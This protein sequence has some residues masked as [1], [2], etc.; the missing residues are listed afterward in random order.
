M[1]RAAPL[2]AVAALLAGCS[3]TAQRSD[4]G[5][6]VLQMWHSQKRQ[7]E[8]TLKLVVE[9]FNAANPRYEVHLS[10]V[11][12]YTA[13]F[14]KARATIQGGTLPDLCIAY[15]SMVAEFMEADV[16]LPLDDSFTHPDHGFTPE[17]QADIFPPFIHCNRYPEFDNKLLSFPFT[18]S[19]LMLYY[20]RD[21]LRSAGIEKPPATWAEFI[22]QCRAIKAKTG[23]PAFA[24]SRDP[25]SFD[26]MIMSLGGTLATL[27]DRRSHLDS[28]EAVRVLD[29]LHTL[30]SDGLATVVAF[31]GDEDRT[32]FANGKV[33]FILRSSTT[34]S[35]MAKDIVDAQGR[36]R[37]EW[38]MACPPAAA[39]KPKLTVLYGGNILIFKSTPERQRGAWEFIKFFVSPENTAEWSVKTGYL[40][41]R[42][43]AADQQVLKDFF[44]Q[45]PRNRSAFD[46]IPHGVREP[47]VAGWQA[48]RTHI[49]T[50]LTRVCM[51]RATPAQAAAKLAQSADAELQRF[52][53]RGK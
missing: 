1:T 31:G 25:S 20:N 32:L 50:A 42:R 41:I 38:G 35:Y 12:S 15:E 24:Y 2:L 8:D 28:P 7:N 46:T 21:I 51:G 5:K 29:M 33:A 37:F 14:Q 53:R 26:G 40:P 13:M 4:T 10:N 44:A 45:H 23:A 3:E 6:L 43:S 18:K 36:D 19:L 11:G 30:I 34:R 39:G 47:S 27:A 9:R 22:E 48:V 16:V 17:E 49:A 52:A